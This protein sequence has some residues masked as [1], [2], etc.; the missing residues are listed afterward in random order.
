MKHFSNNILIAAV[1]LIV[2]SSCSLKEI[3]Y[4]KYTNGTFYK[5]EADAE[6]A[7]MY[8]YLPINY[9]EYAQRFTFYLGDGLTDEF[10]D[11]GR[12]RESVMGWDMNANSEELLYLFK[13]AYISLVR[14][15]TVLENVADMDI[16]QDKK[17]RILGEA[18]FLRAFNHFI[19]AINW[20]SVPIRVSSVGNV[21][22]TFVNPDPIDKVWGVIIDDL[23]KAESLLDVH[24]VQGR[25]DRV[26]AQALLSR[27]YLYLGSYKETGSPGYD[28][29][30]DAEQMYELSAEYA[31]KVINDQNQYWLDPSLDNIYDVNHQKDGPEHIFITG[32]VRDSSGGEG[33]Y[34]KLP[35]LW[36]IQ[37]SDYIYISKSLEPE[38]NTSGKRTVQKVV[39]WK[40]TWQTFRVDYRFRDDHFTRDDLRWRFMVDTVYTET[41]DVYMTFSPDN[42]TSSNTTVNKYYFP[43]CRKYTDPE[44]I[45]DHTSSNVYLIR[46]G[47]VYLNYAEAAGPTEKG[48][49]CVNAVRAR[50]HLS[51]L[52]EGM[53]VTEF[54]DAVREERVRE[55]CFE[56]HY[57][58]DLRRLNR[59]NSKYIRYRNFMKTYAYF[60]PF[61]QRES[62]LNPQNV[63][64]AK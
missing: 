48:Y 53:S 38:K 54:R 15:N 51:P 31:G 49:E 5:T 28:W 8:A 41:G 36:A 13:S 56:A 12:Q 1:I 7:L 19:L 20:G 29:V 52:P 50:A 57:F 2:A 9:I 55:L 34:S 30:E 63:E 21:A 62:D 27:V 45:N 59:V 25:V 4:G 11:Y 22:D 6:S 44:S 60:F 17:N 39:D 64:S 58:Y 47:E 18:Y 46:M 16:A 33:C 10:N 3:T 24:K 43:F 37:I 14:T 61:P 32:M 35:C 42:I 40:T 26:G 23:L